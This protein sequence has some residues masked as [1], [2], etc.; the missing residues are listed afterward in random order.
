MVFKLLNRSSNVITIGSEDKTYHPEPEVGKVYNAFDDGKIT[1]SRLVR[2]KICKKI[3]LD[4]D[5]VSNDLIKFLQEEINLYPWIW[6][7]EQCNIYKAYMIT[8]KCKMDRE[9]GYFYFMKQK[10]SNT[11]FS[12]SKTNWY[13]SLLDTDGYFY[14]Q[15]LSE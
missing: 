1:S 9:A 8:D 13:D 3:N 14:N 2:F 10:D 6:D 7:L 5:K 11:W 4:E 12:A 15:I